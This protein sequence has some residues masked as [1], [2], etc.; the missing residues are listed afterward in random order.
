MSKNSR[1]SSCQRA[2]DGTD[3]ADRWR[4]RTYSDSAI[5]LATSGAVH[6]GC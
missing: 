6:I 4:Y 5:A 1:L 2:S 3:D